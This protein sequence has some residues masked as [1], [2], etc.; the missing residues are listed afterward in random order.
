MVSYGIVIIIIIIIIIVVSVLTDIACK[1]F[2][3][4]HG[5]CIQSPESLHLRK[6]KMSPPEISAKK[7]FSVSPEKDKVMAGRQAV[8]GHS[9]IIPTVCKGELFEQCKN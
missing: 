4:Y 2:H 6:P 5:Y 8:I 9:I 7:L 1:A 3:Y